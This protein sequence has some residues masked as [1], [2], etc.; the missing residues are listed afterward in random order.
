MS[1]LSSVVGTQRILDF[2][3]SFFQSFEGGGGGK[4]EKE[5]RLFFLFGEGYGDG[6]EWGK[7]PW[8]WSF[9]LRFGRGCVGGEKGRE[10]LKY[11]DWGSYLA[12][13]NMEE[14][15]DEELFEECDYYWTSEYSGSIEGGGEGGD[16][17]EGGGPMRGVELR[18]GGGR[19]SLRRWGSL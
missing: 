19:W 3:S 4:R 8:I 9:L 18:E 12:F 14:Y 7:W 17:K 11:I 13:K 10:D 6:G 15:M 2:E 1:E 5:G 16:G